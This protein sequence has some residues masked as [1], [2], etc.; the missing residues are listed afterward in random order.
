MRPGDLGE[1]YR[2]CLVEA[3][4]PYAGRK[5]LGFLTYRC[6]PGEVPGTLR[7]E[8]VRAECLLREQCEELG[9]HRGRHP[10]AG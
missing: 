8:L 3:H 4:C 5:I 2:S 7:Q 1:H 10:L 9:C 6:T